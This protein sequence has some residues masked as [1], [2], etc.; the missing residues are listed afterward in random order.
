MSL[1]NGPEIGRVSGRAL[2]YIMSSLNFPELIF[3][4]GQ[5][6]RGL[7]ILGVRLK[8]ATSNLENVN[9]LSKIIANLYGH[10]EHFMV[11]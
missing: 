6:Y 9:K 11:Y 10:S 4:D 1:D 7:E 5:R 2:R 8:N 3:W